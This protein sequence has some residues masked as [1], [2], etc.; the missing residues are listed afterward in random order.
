[1]WQLFSMSFVPARVYETM[2]QQISDFSSSR[3][4]LWSLEPTPLYDLALAALRLGTFLYTTWHL[5]PYDLALSFIRG[6]SKCQTL[7]KYRST[8]FLVQPLLDK[9]NPWP[10]LHLRLSASPLTL[11]LIPS[12]VQWF[13]PQTLTSSP[14]TL[15]VSA[16]EGRNRVSQP[17]H[18]LVWG[19]GEIR[20]PLGTR[21]LKKFFSSENTTL[22]TDYPILV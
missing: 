16:P 18:W 19:G 12:R 11:N 13:S 17:I 9:E 20:V 15:K 3:L 4:P 21:Q 14:P 6:T 22:Y 10:H 2:V 1:M 8:L 5:R 7:C